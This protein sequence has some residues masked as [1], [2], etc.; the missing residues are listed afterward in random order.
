MIAGMTQQSS[1]EYKFQPTSTGVCITCTFPKDS[2]TA[3]CLVVVHQRIGSSGLM[4]LESSHRFNQSLTGNTAFGC[5]E[6]VNQV[7][8]QIGVADG[9]MISEPSNTSKSSI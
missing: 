6:G 2:S 7:Q 1:I 8:H 5:I 3:D 9:K 4:N